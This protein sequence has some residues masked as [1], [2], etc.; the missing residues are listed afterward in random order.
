MQTIPNYLLVLTSTVIPLLTF[1]WAVYTMRGKAST[2]YVREL[3]ARV[4]ECERKW[5]E[6]RQENKDLKDTNYDLMVSKHKK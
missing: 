2:E 4:A 1:I 6:L 3:E 5:K